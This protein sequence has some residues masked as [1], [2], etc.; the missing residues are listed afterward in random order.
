M[1]RPFLDYARAKGFRET[2]VKR[3]L[4]L[5]EGAQRAVAAIVVPL[6]ASENHV[7]DMLDWL[8]EI[9]LRDGVAIDELLSREAFAAIMGDAR[10]G[11]SDKLKRVKEELRRIRF[12]RLSWV[13]G[14]IARRIRALKLDPRTEMT[15]P[16][17]LEGGWLAVQL[18]ARSQDELKRLLAV[19]SEAAATGEVREIFTLIANGGLEEP[20][21]GNGTI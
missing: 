13:E 7:R 14:E 6:K 2:T 16:K 12:P 8:E 21:T 11:R 20:Q 17:G 18:R 9:C 10:L 5:E 19:L 15:V 3:F 4:S 1:A